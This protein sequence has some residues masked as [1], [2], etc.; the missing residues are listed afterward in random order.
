MNVLSR[1]VAETANSYVKKGGLI[2]LA[3]CGIGLRNGVSDYIHILLP[4]I[5]NCIDDNDAGI[6]FYACESLYNIVKASR[7]D[8]LRFINEIF[9]ALCKL[10][11]DVDVE[12]KDISLIACS[13]CGFIVSFTSVRCVPS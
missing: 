10:Y 11:T 9:I 5:L 8:I 12:V 6:R 4:P 3:S 1:E 2:G 13:L 7:G